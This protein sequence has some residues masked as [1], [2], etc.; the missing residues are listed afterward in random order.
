MLEEATWY[1]HGIH[2]RENVQSTSSQ[3]H[4]SVTYRP[5]IPVTASSRPV[6]QIRATLTL[7]AQSQTVSVLRPEPQT[8]GLGLN[9]NN[10]PQWGNNMYKPPA[11]TGGDRANNVGSNIVCYE[12][13]QPGHMCPN[14]PQLKGNVRAAAVWHEATPPTV[15][16]PSSVPSP[17]DGEQEE[18]ED[19]LKDHPTIEESAA[20]AADVW[21]NNVTPYKWDNQEDTPD[22]EPMLVY[23]S[24]VIRIKG[25]N[26]NET[27][28]CHAFPQASTSP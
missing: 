15:G 20:E 11:N 26:H 27:C 3:P 2:C 18:L 12:C 25:C 23:H 1:H 4:K 10:Y 28:T 16:D 6:P 7:P 5:A 14:C 9:P 8:T 19:D 17:M 22:S 13:G 24:S 21:D